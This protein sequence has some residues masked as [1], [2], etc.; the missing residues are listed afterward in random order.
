MFD[1]KLRT[2]DWFGHPIGLNFDKAGLINKTSWGGIVTLVIRF[3]VSIY[4]LILLKDLWLRERDTTN[5]TSKLVQAENL[6]VVHLNETGFRPFVM[7]QNYTSG[8]Y[9]KYDD[10]LKKI[11]NIKMGQMLMDWARPGKFGV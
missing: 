8:E 2:F 11:I 7:I 10:N 1:F 4:G 9:L 6:G 5:S 3:L